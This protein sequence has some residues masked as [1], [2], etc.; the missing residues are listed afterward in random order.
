MTKYK[1]QQNIE[2]TV[3]A[4]KE[5][6]Q[7]TFTKIAQMNVLFELVGFFSSVPK[8]ILESDQGKEIN[9]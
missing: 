2:P 1:L 9:K 7:K 8:T 6:K 4:P 5:L 3:T